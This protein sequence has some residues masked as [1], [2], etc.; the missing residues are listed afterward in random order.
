MDSILNKASVAWFNHCYSDI[1]KKE[2]VAKEAGDIDTIQECWDK[3]SKM[4]RAEQVRKASIFPRGEHWDFDRERCLSILAEDDCLL[5][6]P[7]HEDD[8]EDFTRV[9]CYWHTLKE[10]P[11]EE[12]DKIFQTSLKD[13]ILDKKSY[14]ASIKEKETN[15]FIGYVSIK[16][17]AVSIWKIAI[18][19]SPDCCSKGYGPAAIKLFL[20]A[21]HKLT[22][23]DEF[24]AL[25]ELDNYPSQHC[26]KKAG[27]KL[28]GL[29]DTVFGD[30][31]IAE[32]FENE[33][34]D[35]I[36]PEI[37]ELAAE[38]HIEPRK[39]L[40]KVLDFRFYFN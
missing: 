39:M 40:S 22:G 19:L 20:A 23:K 34:A 4:I 14:I 2:E 3:L 16:D 25:V 7:I 24:K 5:L 9:R 31:A 15:Q 8:L 30:P 17:T 18:E 33:N 26:M 32:Q 11:T 6:Y 12:M 37:T 1:L 28:Y 38:L 10:E 21:L 27:A 36:T 29:F 35:L 13:E